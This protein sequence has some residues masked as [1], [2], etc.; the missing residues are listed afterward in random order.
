MRGLNYD[1]VAASARTCAMRL[2]LHIGMGKTGTTTLQHTL[3]AHRELL[4][5]AG[6]CYP[7]ASTRSRNHNL[8]MCP[9]L[10]LTSN[11]P[12]EFIQDGGDPESMAAEGRRLWA[13]IRREIDANEPDVVVLSGEYLFPQSVPLLSALRDMLSEVFDEIDVVAYVRDPA[14]YYLAHAQ[15]RVKA[16]YDV[17]APSEF[18]YP[19]RASLLRQTEAFGGRVS[20]RAFDR[21]LLFHRCIVRDFLHTFVPQTD[22]IAE[23]IAVSDH[24]ESMSAEAMCIMQRLRRSGWPDQNNV[25]AP[26]SSLVLQLL[27]SGTMPFPQT[28]ARLRPD[29]EGMIAN[30]FVPWLDWL[31]EQFGVEFRGTP[32]PGSATEG[33]PGEPAA[34]DSRELA[35]ILAI[36][37]AQLERVE[38]GL[39]KELASVVVAERAKRSGGRIDKVA[40]ATT[41]AVPGLRRQA[42]RIADVVTSP[43]ASGRV[44]RRAD[45][46]RVAEADVVAPDN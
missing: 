18:Q 6:V 15:Q 9:F 35:E 32:E 28:P 42:R 21:A 13:D 24:N 25:F 17:P 23:S 30:K 26:E 11:I 8:L 19:V 27:T 22:V 38:L 36:D 1:R 12:R 16:S 4:S 41:R 20:V 34:W 29:I 37:A 5:R 46:E 43:T 14:A 10:P 7:V 39:L 44:A 40:R 33:E 3:S 45:A 31:R 2:L